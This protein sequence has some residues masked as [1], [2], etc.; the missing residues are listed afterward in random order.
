MMGTLPMKTLL[1]FS[2]SSV[3]SSA[4]DTVVTVFVMST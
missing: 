4:A 1:I 2:T 3:L